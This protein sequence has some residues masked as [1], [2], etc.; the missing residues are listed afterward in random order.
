MEKSLFVRTLIAF[1]AIVL[2]ISARTEASE[3]KGHERVVAFLPVPPDKENLI[4]KLISQDDVGRE[5]VEDGSVNIGSD[6]KYA[7]ISLKEGARS[8]IFILNEAR[9]WCGTDGCSLEIWE[10]DGKDWKNILDTLTQAKPGNNVL[11]VQNATDHGYHRLVERRRMG[12]SDGHGKIIDVFPLKPI[13]YMWTG[14]TYDD[15]YDDEDRPPA[16]PK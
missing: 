9:G 1:V 13:H 4:K 14:E 12:Q 8:H 10:F 11:R 16:A 15:D 2:L 6:V 7:E 5:A 3:D